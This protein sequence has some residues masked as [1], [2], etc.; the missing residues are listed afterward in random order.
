MYVC[1]A[2]PYLVN[3]K[4]SITQPAPFGGPVLV[5]FKAS[6]RAHQ[7]ERGDECQAAQDGQDLEL[8]GCTPGVLHII[9]SSLDHPEA[10][11]KCAAQDLAGLAWD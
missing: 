9:H 11:P 7:S 4:A 5:N 10:G 2:G 1:H 8:P 3:F 6:I